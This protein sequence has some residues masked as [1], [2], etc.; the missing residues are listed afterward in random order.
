[1]RSCEGR[2]FL[3]LWSAPLH[4]RALGLNLGAARMILFYYVKVHLFVVRFSCLYW[5]F[6]VLLRS[7]YLKRMSLQELYD[8]LRCFQ[9]FVVALI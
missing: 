3:L 6:L 9:F 5:L 2:L 8:F 1:M 4:P 7:A